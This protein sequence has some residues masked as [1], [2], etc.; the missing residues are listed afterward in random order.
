MQVNSRSDFCRAKCIE[1]DAAVLVILARDFDVEGCVE[2]LERRVVAVGSGFHEDLAAP[3]REY[4]G[5][6]CCDRRVRRRE[7]ASDKGKAKK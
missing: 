7:D 4:L 5:D 6:G 2:E 3:G 1:D